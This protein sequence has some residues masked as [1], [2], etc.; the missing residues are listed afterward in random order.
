L[1]VVALNA[2]VI[3]FISRVWQTACTA[4]R[5]GDEG[6]VID[7]PVFPDELEAVP[8]ILDQATFP[9]SGLLV[10]HADW[11]HL[12]GRLAYP[13]AALGCGGAT[14]A[15]LE[16]DPGAAAR[17]LRAFD[18]E[19]YVSGRPP[20]GLDDLQVLPVPGRVGLGGQEMEMQPAAGHTSDG[21]AFWV[22]WL[23]V[24]IAGDY[25]SPVEI[26][27]ISAAGGSP[28]EYVA[29]LG[30]LRPL[31]ARA[32]TVVAG[33]GGPMPPD[34][35]IDLLD[36]DL[37]YLEELRVAGAAADLP[38]GRGGDVQRRIHAANAALVAR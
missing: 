4:V 3:V 8:A 28:D 12:L 2:D 21:V 27:M 32:E 30:R 31:V 13:N 10:T 33:H 38:A 24:L 6:C 17:D 25:L 37:A 15:R 11:D 14:A 34:R 7:S 22:P 16:A 9:V 19:Y 36:Q 29:T 1:Q 18:E 20:P 26:P 23:G 35:A 5:A